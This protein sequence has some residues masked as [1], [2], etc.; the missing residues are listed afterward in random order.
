MVNG[1]LHTNNWAMKFKERENDK[2]NE[3]GR[4]EDQAHM[5]RCP[6]QNQT[7]QRKIFKKE[8]Q[9]K[10]IKENTSRDIIYLIMHG[11]RHWESRAKTWY[12]P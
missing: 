8:L 6:D 11:I 9:E 2:C 4:R 7:E 10:M 12:Q 3:C 1:I 5:I